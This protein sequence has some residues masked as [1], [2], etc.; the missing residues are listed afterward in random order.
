MRSTYTQ[1]DVCGRWRDE[2]MLV[3]RVP[4][5]EGIG[6]EAIAVADGFPGFTLDVCS[7][8][9][10][11]DAIAYPG[12]FH[13]PEITAFRGMLATWRRERKGRGR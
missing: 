13:R 4:V 5:A 7:R 3:L 10:A 9:C 12:L 8:E 2:H 6:I 1:C 11:V